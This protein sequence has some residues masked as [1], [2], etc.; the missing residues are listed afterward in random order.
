MT[1]TKMD[2]PR[3]VLTRCIQAGKDRVSDRLTS[4]MVASL[5]L[6]AEKARRVDSNYAPQGSEGKLDCGCPASQAGL[7]FEDDIARDFGNGF[8]AEVVIWAFEARGRIN[9]FADG[10]WEIVG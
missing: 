3:D 1:P 5:A 4:P 7:P 10:G 6:V 2:M 8:D 9:P